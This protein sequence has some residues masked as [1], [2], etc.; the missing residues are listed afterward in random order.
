M[1]YPKDLY[2]THYFLLYI[3]DI[4]NSSPDKTFVLY[5][6]D[7]NIFVIENTKEKVYEKSNELLRNIHLYMLSNQLHINMTKCNYIYFKSDITNISTCQRDAYVKSSLS[8]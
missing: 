8:Q 4:F 3:N 1:V 2:L 7:T 5:A 6:D